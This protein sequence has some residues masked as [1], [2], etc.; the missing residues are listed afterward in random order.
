M[1]RPTQPQSSRL[2]VQAATSAVNAPIEC[3]SCGSIFF[4]EAQ[5]GMY[6]TSGAGY[7]NVN[8]GPQKVYL[9]P[10]GEI[11]IPSNYASGVPAGS[12]RD[13]FVQS[14]KLAIAHRNSNTLDQ[15]AQGTVSLTEH[16]RLKA[17]FEELAGRFNTWAAG[18]EVPEPIE[19]DAPGDVEASEEEEAVDPA[20]RITMRELGAAPPIATGMR[21]R[22][23]AAAVQ[24]TGDH[25]EITSTPAT[26]YTGGAR[27][28]MKRQGGQ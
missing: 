19:V 4:I 18:G 2:R 21:G 17:Q 10:C 20:S 14:L 13:L 16:N 9:C 7:R 28:R 11:M 6:T 27:E 1:N 25:K 23:A 15:V 26:I 22:S 5:A 24:S 8:Q 12:E 3:P